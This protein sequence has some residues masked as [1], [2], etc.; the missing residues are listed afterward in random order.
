M[1]AQTTATLS[2]LLHGLQVRS[3]ECVL[4][5]DRPTP[6]RPLATATVR[7]LAGHLLKFAHRAVVRRFFKPSHQGRALLA[8]NEGQDFGALAGY[9]PSHIPPAYLF[10]A[11]TQKPSCSD[12]LRVII[13]TWDS[14]GELISAFRE[15][16]C[17]ARG[18][19]FGGFDR[20]MG[21]EPSKVERVAFF[22]IPDPR[23]TGDHCSL[24]PAVIEFLTPLRLKVSQRF[25]REEEVT[26]GHLTE[27][28]VRR[29]NQ[30][31]AVYGDKT[32]LDET[33]FQVAASKV[34]EISRSL[35]WIKQWG[36]SSTQET[37]INLSGPIGQIRFAELPG[38]LAD[39][40]NAAALFHIGHKT[41]EGCGQLRLLG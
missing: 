28:A 17:H 7:G 27:A 6:I 21:R 25:L 15:V 23:C 29:L 37:E 10:E 36:F 33:P 4:H 5:F 18:R 20:N 30:L 3:V 1:A 9:K 11:V 39:L 19:P 40:L 32:E 2:K 24:H 16:L 41:A 35:C 26:L 34:R 22:E 8:A 31:S 12:S 14:D 38:V 13:R